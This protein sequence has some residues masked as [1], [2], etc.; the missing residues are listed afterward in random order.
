MPSLRVAENVCVFALAWIQGEGQTCNF[1][2]DLLRKPF[3]PP[4]CAVH[5]LIVQFALRGQTVH[6]VR[7]RGYD[8]FSMNCYRARVPPDE[9][10]EIEAM[11][12]MPILVGEW[13]FGAL[14]VGLPGSGIGLALVRAIVGRHAGVVDIES[15]PGAGTVV[16][17]Y[18]VAQEAAP[19]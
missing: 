14:D 15:T 17:V 1:P 8:V 12:G 6:S 10:A 13:H 5:S 2:T 11:L 7:Q 19:V 9:V 16:R 4:L 18:L 3:T